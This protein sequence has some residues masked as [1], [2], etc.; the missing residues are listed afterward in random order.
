[1][2]PYDC[3]TR[4]LL[5][6]CSVLGLLVPRD[7]AAQAAYTVTELG[8]LGGPTTVARDMNE[9]GEVVGESKLADGRSH[10]FL[11]T[12]GQLKDLGTLGGRNS[13]AYGIND[14]GLI[15]GR[16][17]DSTGTERPFV[18]FRFGPLVDLSAIDLILRTAFSTVLTVN[19]SDQVFG[20]RTTS[21][22]HMAARNRV[23][24]YEQGKIVDLGTFGGED[25]IVTASNAA[26]Q[27]AGHFGT[28]AHADYAD[29]RAFLASGGTISVLPSLGGGV[30]K[31]L[32]LNN[33]AQVVGFSQLLSGQPHAFL[34]TG[35][36][37]TDLGTLPG[38]SQSVAFAINDAGQVV[39]ASDSSA[40]TQ[41]AFLYANGVMRDLN[42]L[43]SS[44]SGWV[45][46]EAADINNA[47]QIVGNGL[48]RGQRRAFLLTPVAR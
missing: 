20:Y 39:G 41:H 43:I 9:L 40:R 1:V 13:R 5:S 19:N 30:T 46:N 12:G 23:F 35:S 26:G 6:L 18:A 14:H 11:Y 42:T 28:E 10:A 4:V 33:L 15:G 17:E 44:T 24:V 21:T 45:L 7:G 2:R 25:G 48:F 8:T 36:V 27:L 37:L 22:E 29:R 3:S 16:A 38:G 47:G 31:A 34:Y 32:A